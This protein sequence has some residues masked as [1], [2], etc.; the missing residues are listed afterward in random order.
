M[1]D[2]HTPLCGSVPDVLPCILTEDHDGMYHEDTNGYRWPTAAAMRQAAEDLRPVGL[3]A[4]LEYVAANLPDEPGEKNAAHPV[5]AGRDTKPAPAEASAGF[6][7]PGHTY[8]SSTLSPSTTAVPG[9]TGP[10]PGAP[11]RLPV[12][13]RPAPRRK[14]LGPPAQPRLPTPRLHV[15]AAAARHRHTDPKD[16]PLM[17]EPMRPVHAAVLV[18]TAL[19]LAGCTSQSASSSK[20]VPHCPAATRTAAGDLVPHGPR[21]C[22]LTTPGSSTRQDRHTNTPPKT[23]D[24]A[25]AA[26]IRPKQPAAPAKPNTPK[27]PAAPAPALKKLR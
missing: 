22:L 27:Q 3:D 15:P 20:S 24:K 8:T 23:S 7:Q 14:P 11:R 13:T 17:R 25:P 4:L 19:L 21:P 12:P 1:N 16:F 5:S 2:Q 9:D 18:A 26:P 6:Y 10:R